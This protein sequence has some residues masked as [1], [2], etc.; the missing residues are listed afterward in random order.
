M[1]PCSVAQPSLFEKESIAIALNVVLLQLLP[2]LDPL[3]GDIRGI[4]I[5]LQEQRDNDGLFVGA[6]DAD[7]IRRRFAFRPA[8]ARLKPRARHAVEK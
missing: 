5:P 1:Q 2:G 3:L 6:Q 4:L 7:N 8:D